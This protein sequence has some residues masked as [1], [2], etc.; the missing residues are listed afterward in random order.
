LAAEA[1]DQGARWVR[2]SPDDVLSHAT[3][4]D[5][6]KFGSTEI[7]WEF[8]YPERLAGSVVSNASGTGLF[9]Y[10]IQKLEFAN[11]FIIDDRGYV[12]AEALAYL[13]FAMSR[14]ENVINPPFAGSLAGYTGT[15]LTQWRLVCSNGIM[16]T[17]SHDIGGPEILQ[18]CGILTN[19]LC[20]YGNWSAS[21]NKLRRQSGQNCR[22]S[23]MYLRY[24]LPKGE[25]IIVWFVDDHLFGFE[26]RTNRT[27]DLAYYERRALAETAALFNSKSGIR[28]GQI[29][30]F[31]G[32]HVTFG[33][34][35]PLV[36][37]TQAN[38]LLK[39]AFA[40][41]LCYILLGRR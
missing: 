23:E 39:A 20:D 14:F 35:S 30:C 36:S 34:I 4:R 16:Q 19:N 32:R 33:S 12:A 41:R 31:F 17:P 10:C 5:Q 2:L 29:I 11:Q 6:I 25:P 27:V 1:T 40:R 9:C 13:G 28:M 38:P 37:F 18:S 8:C 15:L 22:P 7:T 3:I 21:R 26:A 24:D